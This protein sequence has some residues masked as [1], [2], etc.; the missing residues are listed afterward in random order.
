[1]SKKIFLSNGGY[2]LVS[3]EDHI[4]LVGYNWSQNE[5]GHVHCNNGIDKMHNQSMS[6]IIAKRIGLNLSKLIDHKDR[7][8]LNNCRD[9]LR[10]ATHSQNRA[11][12]KRH[13]ESGYK[14]VYRNGNSWQARI[15]VNGKSIHLGYF[16]DPEKAHKV[17]CKAAVKYH[18]EFACFG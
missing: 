15:N 9:N 17:Y 8:P 13:S 14:G 10:A 12:S 11:N 5:K 2:T 1:M 16:D 18:G 7:N 3:D 6:R 4:F